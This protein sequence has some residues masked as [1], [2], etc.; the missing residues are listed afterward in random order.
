[1]LCDGRPC[2][3]HCVKYEDRIVEVCAPVE[4]LIGIGKRNWR[5]GYQ[6]VFFPCQNS[7]RTIEKNKARFYIQK[8]DFTPYQTL[9]NIY[10]QILEWEKH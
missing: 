4:K 3:Y 1:M 10:C 5:T 6:I 9:G 8:L 2:V 7:S